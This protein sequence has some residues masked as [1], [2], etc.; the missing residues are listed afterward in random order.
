MR[1]TRRR[2]GRFELDVEGLRLFRDGRRVKIQPQPLRMLLALTDRPGELVTRDELRTLIWG[3]ATYVEF[4]QG[5]GYCARQIRLALADD[6]GQKGPL[7]RS[8][9]RLRIIPL[10]TTPTR[11]RFRQ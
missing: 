2:F 9:V 11:L 4:D 5:L 3:H 8:P 10:L 6:A 7:P 1:T